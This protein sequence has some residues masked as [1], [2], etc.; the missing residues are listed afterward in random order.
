MRTGG[1]GSLQPS[2]SWHWSRIS[3]TGGPAGSSC[4]PAGAQLASRA[5]PAATY[6]ANIPGSI[7]VEHRAS[8]ARRCVERAE[9]GHRGD[10]LRGG[11][12]AERDVGE[13]RGSAA[14]LEI[15]FGHR[16]VGKAGRDGEAQY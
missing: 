5:A 2:L 7:G 11:D 14:A 1:A 8:H 3:V 15:V 4:A 9:R 6:L 13:Q 12:A 10:L 16:R